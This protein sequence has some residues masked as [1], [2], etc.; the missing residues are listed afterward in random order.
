MG[1]ARD[2]R[3]AIW[4]VGLSG[5]GKSAIA[6]AIA[7][8]LAQRAR[9][10]LVLD[11]DELRDGLN[12]DLG[13]GRAD[14]LEAARRTAAVSVQVAS[15]GV[16]AVTAMITPYRR[17]GTAARAAHE[18]AGVAFFEVWVATPI[19]VCVARDRKGLYAAARRGQLTGMTGIDDP[20][21]E[22]EDPDCII[23]AS[24]TPAIDLARVVLSAAG[25]GVARLVA[26]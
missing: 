3:L 25:S 11:G 20:F 1:A 9:P 24:V 16:V 5:A 8:E 17:S 22:P 7:A 10:V 26:R 18:A 2:A 13:F 19:E 12:A 15:A 6:Q 4:L 14:R 21:E 23:D